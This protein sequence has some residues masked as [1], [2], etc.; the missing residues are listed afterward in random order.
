M[1]KL[2]PNQ[3]KL[4][5]ILKEHQANP[6]TMEELALQLDI[7]SKSVVFYH[8]TQLEKKGYITRSSNNPQ[9][10]YINDSNEDV[11]YLPLYGMAKCGPAGTILDGTPARIIPVDPSLVRFPVRHGFAMEAKGDSMKELI[12]NKDWLIVEQCDNPKQ[13]D[14][15]VCSNNGETMVKRFVKDKRSGKILL[16]SDNARY[17]P[18]ITDENSLKIAGIVRSIIKRGL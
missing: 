9:Q 6:L 3:E 10:Y 18:I 16:V 14:V 11:I 4:L 15:I 17:M 1:K 8:I 13:R 7:S 12:N 5:K 2:H